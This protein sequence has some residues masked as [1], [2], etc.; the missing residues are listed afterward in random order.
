MDVIDTLMERNSGFSADGFTPGLPLLPQ[1]RTL[2]LTCV[3]PRVDPAHV[4]GVAPGEAAVIRNIGGRLTPN[5]L[6]EVVLLGRLA[7]ALGGVTGARGD[8]IVMH[9]TDCGITRLQ[10]PPEML[11]DYFRIDPALLVDKHVA[12][13]YAA[14]RDD[15]AVLR[16]VAPIAAAFRVTGM[17]YDVETG[18]VE[19]VTRE[20]A[21]DSRSS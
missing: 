5:V 13:P 9:H 16:G 17:V 2:L 15:V 4:V 19:V 18:R 10:D 3:D 6:A 7:G 20:A 1:F 11:A 14:V 21:V 8:L 12:D